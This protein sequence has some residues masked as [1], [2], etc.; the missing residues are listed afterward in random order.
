VRSR[1][2]RVVCF[3]LGGVLVAHCRSWAEGCERAGIPVRQADW[4]A[5][6]AAKARRRAA[7][8]VYQ[9]GQCCT[10]DYYAWL[11]EAF[12][13]LYS[14]DEVACVHRAWILD[15]YP[16]AELLVHEL[17][18]DPRVSTACLSNTNAAHWERLVATEGEPEFPACVRLRQRLASHELGWTKPEPRVFAIAGERFGV[19]G[20]RILLFDDNLRNVEAARRAGWLAEQI[21]YRGDTALQI[22]RWLQHYG[23]GA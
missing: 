2:P 18:A 12:D 16:G 4:L 8:E 21:D 9:R 5:S 13:G 7:I 1:P 19:P 22:R 17:N 3:D 6:E 20:E 15:E 23:L 14:M 10:A 11:V